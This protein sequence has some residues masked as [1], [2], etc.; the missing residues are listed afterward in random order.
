MFKLK[1]KGLSN[2]Y[3]LDSSDAGRSSIVP[4]SVLIYDVH[5]ARAL[6]AD[7]TVSEANATRVLLACDVYANTGM[8]SIYNAAS[9]TPRQVT[10]VPITEKF[11][12]AY[13]FDYAVPKGTLFTVENGNIVPATK[14]D[15]VVF[16]ALEGSGYSPSDSHEVLL[17]TVFKRHVTEAESDPI[18]TENEAS[19]TISINDPATIP[20]KG[21]ETGTIGI[22]VSNAYF[23]PDLYD[24]TDMWAVDFGEENDGATFSIDNIV[25]DEDGNIT[26]VI[27][28]L[29]APAAGVFASGTVSIGL[30]GNALIGVN[31][32]V[33]PTE[34]V[35]QGYSAQIAA[36]MYDEA[37]HQ[38]G[39][40]LNFS[41]AAIPGEGDFNEDYKVL[42]ATPIEEDDPVDNT[43]FLSLRKDGD[44]YSEGLN[45]MA[46]FMRSIAKQGL[47]GTLAVDGGTGEVTLAIANGEEVGVTTDMRVYIPW[48]DGDT[49]KLS[50]YNIETVAP[51]LL[52]LTLVSTQI[53]EGNVPAPDQEY[54]NIWIFFSVDSTFLHDIPAE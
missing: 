3:L 48:V 36:V 15:L 49:D 6:T 1:E 32:D 7:D 35:I 23:N 22:L 28:G 43:Y 17:T 25:E 13:D 10:A 29:S 37:Y 27:M 33:D 46:C 34:F 50:I 47:T 5:G 12:F 26:G 41:G 44:G 21:G 40:V 45:E 20:L 38:A 8:A 24:D 54:T 11:E 31:H 14:D 39:K 19:L 2:S 30:E 52:T 18:D 4:G 53:V 51:E 16:R 42:S 9:V